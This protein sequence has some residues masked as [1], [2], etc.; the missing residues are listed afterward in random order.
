MTTP[1]SITLSASQR[2]ILE[3][4]AARADGAVLPLPPRIKGGVA[5]NV[6]LS[7][8][9]KGLITLNETGESYISEEGLR[10]VG[11]P[12]AAQTP[13]GA[14][15]TLVATNLPA[16][17]EPAHT[18]QEPPTTAA[19]EPQVAPGLRPETKQASLITMLKQPGGV[20][21]E[22]IMAA[23]G[24][25]RHTVRGAISAVLRKKLGLTV[26]S[27]RSEGCTVYRISATP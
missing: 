13:V 23:T 9:R 20:T 22:Q 16:T 25:Q 12:A 6:M 11:A 15:E 21:L 1:K 8:T 4:A 27:E 26:S 19:P 2:A 24:W 10:A 3:A 17:P 7:L 14:P 18:A 5:I